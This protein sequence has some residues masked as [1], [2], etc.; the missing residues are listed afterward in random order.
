MNRSC[1]RAIVIGGSMA[2][3]L[4]AR[5]LSDHVEQVT[6]IERDAFIDAPE[7]RKG[8]PQARHLHGLLV[9][10]F[11]VITH[12]FPALPQALADSGAIFADMAQSMRWY[13]YGGY[14]A[15][16]TFGMR[17]SIMSRPFLEWQIRR[18][19][20]ALPNVT[21]RDGW[22]VE[23]LLATDD[24]SRITGVE[25]ARRDATEQREKLHADLVV[26]TGGRGS[27]APQWL[28]ALGYARPEERAVTCG[29]AYATRL[30][31]RD[32]DAPGSRDW[33]F[34]TPDAPREKRMG[35][36][37]PVEGDRWI[38]SLGGWHGDHAPV[39]EA[40]FNAFAQSL[41]A[42]DVYAIV[43]GCEP[44]SGIVL[45]KFPASLRRH[46]EKLQRFP[47]GYLVLGDAVCSFNPLYGQG[48]TAAALQAAELD[49]LL[50]DRGG[51]LEGIAKPYF[52]RVSRVI[53]IPWQTAV[54]EDFRFP[55]TRG[56]KAP[57]TDLINAYV[58]R[59]HRATHHDP[60]VGAAFLRVMNLI[61][62][63]S[64]L[65]HPRIFWRVLRHAARAQPVGDLPT[66]PR[67]TG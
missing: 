49:T 21:V 37:F 22:S 5:V 36:A 64:S 53:D 19:V 45:H 23:R 35:G 25:I 28:A 18:M 9:R 31:R 55:E 33:V 7:A 51:R 54:G 57:G 39:D 20:I 4:A 63:P 16:F 52:R 38:V 2:G 13:C 42:P 46:Y 65:L 56:P 30:Y 1:Q 40:G 61:E 48:M 43:S 10:G 34:I 60:V 66:T 14:R 12:Y 29:V 67:V 26:D 41:P 44:L 6:L 3:L 50:T 27:H 32:P 8:Q 17:G 47:E 62:P 24:H 11:E 58:A 15:R 59:V